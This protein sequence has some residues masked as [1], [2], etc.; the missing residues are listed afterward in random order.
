M[1]PIIART[2]QTP[3]THVQTNSTEVT[4]LIR[5]HVFPQQNSI[6][7]ELD[8]DNIDDNFSIMFAHAIE[9]IAYNTNNMKELK[10]VERMS[11][12]FYSSV[13]EK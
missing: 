9:T 11:I 7:F 10:K 4:P 2:Q 5:Q 6:I 8:I 13:R 1:D 3:L 12:S